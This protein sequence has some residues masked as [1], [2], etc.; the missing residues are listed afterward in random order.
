M[1]K[2]SIT[3][4]VVDA[5]GKFHPAGT[6]NPTRTGAGSFGKANTNHLDSAIATAA[7]Q[8]LQGK[9]AVVASRVTDA[10]GNSRV[11]EHGVVRP[12]LSNNQIGRS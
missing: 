7:A 6:P 9:R 11:V 12:G 2:S 8:T 3:H 10:K 5:K 1:A 4:G